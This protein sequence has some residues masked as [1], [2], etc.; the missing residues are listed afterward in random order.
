M[1]KALQDVLLNIDHGIVM[2]DQD[3]QITVW[4]KYMQKIMNIGSEDAVSHNIY[5][6]LPNLNK[7]HFKVAIESAF[8]NGC[9]MFFSDAMHRGLV[10]EKEHFNVKLSCIDINASKYILL[11]FIDVTNEYMRIHLLRNN[12]T[13]LYLLNKGLKDE[14]KEI[15]KIAYYDELTGVAN[16]TLFYELA[17][18]LIA[19]AKRNHDLLGL[20]FIDVNQFKSINDTYGHEAGDAM[21][22][23][24]A[25][26][27]N[28]STRNHDVVARYGGDEFL[29]LLPHLKHFENYKVIVSKIMNTSDRFFYIGEHKIEI[30]LSMGF[31]FY[32]DNG[33]RI[34]QLIEAADHAMY[35]AKRERKICHCAP[36]D[37]VNGDRMNQEQ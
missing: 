8:A 1:D 25:D 30:S 31:S 24:V 17:E 5:Q 14:Q 6:V 36:Y 20:I 12:M 29:V 26:L 27:L 28:N 9:K 19:D 4:N 7:N 13:Q 21:L 35:I 10:S 33:K 2:F 32:P 22:R 11:E 37:F 18:K 3:Y 15:K 34:H 16:R 23:K